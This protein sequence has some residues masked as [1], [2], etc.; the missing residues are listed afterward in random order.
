MYGHCRHLPKVG[1]LVNYQDELMAIVL[2]APLSTLGDY[3][4]YLLNKELI[5][6]FKDF[7]EIENLTSKC[8]K[9]RYNTSTQYFPF[10]YVDTLPI[11][12]QEKSCIKITLKE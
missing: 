11:K 8:I 2:I 5:E 9:Q 7:T 12:V 10:T 1:D 3:I 6:E 4:V